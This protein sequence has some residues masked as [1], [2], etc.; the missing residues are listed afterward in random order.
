[1]DLWRRERP[2]MVVD[3]NGV[4]LGVSNGVQECKDSGV[5]AQLSSFASLLCS[6]S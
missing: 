4:P 5:C 3:K 2:H 6:I 1:M